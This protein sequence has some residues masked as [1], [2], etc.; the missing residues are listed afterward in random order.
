MTRPP[1]RE[2]TA[3][4]SLD[5]RKFRATQLPRIYQNCGHNFILMLTLM[6]HPKDPPTV[7]LTLREI[8]RNALRCPIAD[9]VAE[10][11]MAVADPHNENAI[12]HGVIEI[13]VLVRR[14]IE[15]TLLSLLDDDRGRGGVVQLVAGGRFLHN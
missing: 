7:V 5:S 13:V 2:S 3:T 14:G 15:T 6:T 11:S 4:Y 12:V 10:R 1:T 8:E 9:N